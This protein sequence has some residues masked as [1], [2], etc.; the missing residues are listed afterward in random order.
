M[1]Y[2]LEDFC[3]EARNSLTSEPGRD[4]LEEVRQHLEKLLS[5]KDFV[6]KHLGPNSKNG[7]RKLFEDKDNGF[8]ILAH[9]RGDQPAKESP[10]HDH[11]SSWAIYGQATEYSDIAD[12]ERRDD[13]GQEGHAELERVKD[14]RLDQACAHIYD[15]GDIHSV[16]PAPNARF[17]RVTGTDLTKVERLRFEPDAEQVHP[18]FS[19]ENLFNEC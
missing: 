4:G 12:W 18:E 16:N 9:L 2:T 7:T 13:G 17:I 19:T 10:P 6:A 1:A 5:N 3:S 15:I 11:G 8:C 14:Y